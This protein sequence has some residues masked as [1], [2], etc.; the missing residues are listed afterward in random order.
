MHPLLP[1]QRRRI[2]LGGA[3]GPTHTSVISDVQSQR[4]IR[5][6]QK[7]EAD[8]ALCIQARWR[9]ILGRRRVKSE[10]L[11]VFELNVLGING[12]RALVIMGEE[13]ALEVWSKAV[14]TRGEDGIFSLASGPNRDSWM[15]LIR[16]VAA[17]ALRC[18]PNADLLRILRILVT[19]AAVNRHLGSKGDLFVASLMDDLLRQRFQEI[20]SGWI[21]F[22]PKT[23]A[24]MPLLAQLSTAP[25]EI[26]S[27]TSPQY[28]EN[29]ISF[30]RNTL[31]IP[32]LPNL[33]PIKSL[34]EFSAKIP[35]SHI[36]VS[37]DALKS[38]QSMD[39]HKKLHMLANLL[40]FTPSR[41]T[42]L[43]L[44]SLDAYL[45]ILTALLTG[46]P[47]RLLDSSAAE[48][49]ARELV[50]SDSDAS[51][52]DTSDD[53]T[54]ITITIDPR[55]RKRI[56]VLPTA[57]HLSSLLRQRSAHSESP[58]LISF[59]AALIGHSGWPSKKQ[60]V[61]DA[62]LAMPGGGASAYIAQIY[63]SQISGR[64]FDS[65]VVGKTGN[66]KSDIVNAAALIL[67][68]DLF[69]QT[70]LTMGDDEFF[71][72]PE[73]QDATAPTARAVQNPLTKDE[74][75]DLTRQ[76]MRLV[77]ELYFADGDDVN[78]SG[79]RSA[80]KQRGY[81]MS[82]NLK[83]LRDNVVRF[84]LAVH[85]RDSRR[86]FLPENHW[87]AETHR[88]INKQ[89]FVEVAAREESLRQNPETPPTA[90]ERAYFAPRLAILHSV[91]FALSFLTR[92]A[93]FQRWLS[94]TR[95]VHRTHRHAD[96]RRGGHRLETDITIRRDHV[97]EDG[98]AQ[99]HDVDFRGRIGVAFVDKLGMREGNAGH[100]GLYKEFFTAICKEIFQPGRGLW[101][102]N[103]KHE[104]YPNPSSSARSPE[105]LKWFHFIGRVLGKALYDGILI[106]FA[107]A[108]FFLAKWLGRQVYL[109][110]LASLDPTLYKGL[111]FL[112]HYTGDVEDL[113]LT[114][115]AD[116]DDDGT[117]RTVDLLPNGS[118]IAVTKT[119]RLQYIYLIAHLRLSWQIKQQSQAF[120][121]GLSE[122]IEP[123]WLKMFNQQELQTLLGGTD[124]DSGIDVEDLRVNTEYEGVFRM[125]AE[126]AAGADDVQVEEMDKPEKK[127][128]LG[129]MQQ[130]H[131]TIEA[132]WN[133]VRTFDPKER[134]ALLHFVTSCS[135]APLLGFKDLHPH[136]TIQDMGLDTEE[137]LPAAATCSNLLLL[138]RYTDEGILREKLLGAIMSESGF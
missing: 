86:S 11:R 65:L 66:D 32:L 34:T 57:T 99:L 115:T 83:Q 70:L 101:A 45:G 3:A 97:A 131:P 102:E 80:G 50:G 95:Q 33:L 61:L 106:D 67:L 22:T 42:K 37:D 77:L 60:E 35:L 119:N 126:E 107:F 51:D 134:R 52:M 49:H 118:S 93:I 132:F 17:M 19:P 4:A 7:L 108:G 128:F 53:Q 63:R 78:T 136:F 9:G 30:L 2:N 91:P 20:I 116:I 41:Y 76:L 36:R 110:G 14:L 81:G 23:D 48:S 59:V 28:Q 46:L 29:L 89:A 79:S 120:F 129:Q 98:F 55:A 96:A 1:D 24:A 122:L 39:V 5:Q 138:P 71:A 44:Q 12:L 38:L 111:I 54:V 69:T 104:I 137:H 64:R 84:L 25:F 27:S 94:T 74:L 100:R 133:V 92:A 62:V 88:Y 75:V 87:H 58:A 125:R 105:K 47:P 127:K 15:F 112:K 18:Q 40:A 72:F 56:D 113:A 109:D 6:R 73:S 130:V 90:R 123:R 103:D 124:A 117:L 13:D 85:A 68:L 8:S 10:L 31:T 135:R 26:F 82:A 121:A 43:D 114:F 16:R 21:A